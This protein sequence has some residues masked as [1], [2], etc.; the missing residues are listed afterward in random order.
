MRYLSKGFAAAALAG[1]LMAPAPLAAQDNAEQ[2]AVTTGFWLTTPYPELTIPPGETESVT[3]T[4]RNE[5]LPPQRASIEVAGVPEEWK[6]ALKGGGNE[7]SAAMVSMDSTERLT[8]ELTPPGDAELATHQIEVRARTGSGTVTLPL[9]VRISDDAPEAGGLELE[10]EL[11]ALRGTARSTFSYKVKVAN[12]TPEEGLFNLAADVPPGF[13]TR[14]KKGYGSDEITGLPIGASATET[15]T[16]EVVPPRAT[17]AGRYPVGFTVS[18]NGQTATAELSLEVTGEPAVQIVGPQERL[19]GEAQA[20]KETSFTFTLFNTGSAPAKDIE[21]SATP[22]TGW[23]VDFEP[24]LVDQIAPNASDK[25]AVKITPSER[26]IAGDY[27]VAVR[28]AGGPV[29]EE[30]QFR[31]TVRTSTLWGIAGLGVIAAAVLVLGGAV[32]R[33]G[34]R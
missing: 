6:W 15:V 21:L 5:K 12:D 30:V 32:M 26:A 19:S 18:G 3:L 22:P 14:F 13:R 27:M 23:N 16:V 34:R 28:A 29:S 11:P 7:V 25:V 8:L 17:A 24:K 31:T 20:G 10:P 4:L 9:A 33:Y 1:L 2:P